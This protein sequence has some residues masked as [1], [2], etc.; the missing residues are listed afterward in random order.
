MTLI[1]MPLFTGHFS[2]PINRP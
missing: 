1:F 2:E